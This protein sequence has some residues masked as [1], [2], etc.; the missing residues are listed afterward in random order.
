MD[1]KKLLIAGLIGIGLVL[2][3]GVFIFYNSIN[4]GD[5]AVILNS[6]DSYAENSVFD[7]ST[8][9]ATAI[10]IARLNY[11]QWGFDE[12]SIKSVHL[13]SNRKQ[14]VVK[15]TIAYIKMISRSLLLM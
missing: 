3:V 12:G 9:E 1:R 6:T 8:P 11:G 10:S 4:M 14:W 5:P 13:T 2:V 7:N 15:Y